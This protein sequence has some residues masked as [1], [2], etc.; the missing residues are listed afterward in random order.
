M[1]WKSE[2]R[3]NNTLSIDCCKGE[4]HAPLDEF[5]SPALLLLRSLVLLKS[6][7]QRFLLPTA[8]YLR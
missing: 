6:R 2:T 7:R 1:A 3:E 4:T 8:G 5:Y